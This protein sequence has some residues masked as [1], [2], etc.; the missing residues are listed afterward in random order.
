MKIKKLLSLAVLMMLAVVSLTSCNS[1]DDPDAPPAIE[2]LA[3]YQWSDDLNQVAEVWVTYTDFTGRKMRQQVNAKFWN[4]YDASYMFPVSNSYHVEIVPRE[5]EYLQ[6]SY[7]LEMLQQ[8]QAV[9]YWHGNRNELIP[10]NPA[11]VLFSRKNVP[12]SEMKKVLTLMSNMLKDRSVG[13]K[14][15]LDASGAVVIVND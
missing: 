15:M 6:E 9:A 7:D 10:F 8:Y 5:T 2:T 1:D 11:T 4:K 14:Y 13:A 3:Q 12:A